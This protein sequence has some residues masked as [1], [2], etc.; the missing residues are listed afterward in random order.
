[1]K[2]PSI[3]AEKR[4][5]LGK[6]VK[7]LRKEGVLPANLY[8]RKVKSQALQLN[9]VNFQ[10]AYKGA[11]ET[12]LVNLKVDKEKEA[13]P[14]LIHNVQLHPVSSQFLHA[15]FHQVALKEKMKAEIPLIVK[16]EAPAVSQKKGLLIQTLNKLEI[17]AL[18]TDLPEKIEV[19]VSKLESVDQEIKVA[20]LPISKRTSVLTDKNL[21]VAKIGALEEE[22]AEK[23]VEK[24]EE[25]ETEEKVEEKKEEKEE[26]KSPQEKP[27]GKPEG[28]PKKGKEKRQEA[29]KQAS[30]SKADK[31]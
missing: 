28:E 26:E 13:R 23:P 30:L 31:N 17:E 15:D 21:V 7:K 20:D 2:R 11:G 27:K 4:K 8:G 5:I 18:P 14:V 25:K 3:R 1:M 29:S 12:G 9:L 10:K 22:V 24:P 19:D 6:K 16:G